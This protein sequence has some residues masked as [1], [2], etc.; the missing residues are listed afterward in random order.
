MAERWPRD[1]WLDAIWEDPAL[2]PNERVVAYVYARYAG[3]GDTAWVSWPE[4]M[5][6]TGMTSKRTVSRALKVLT[7][8]GWLTVV[9]RARQHRSTVYR[10]T[11]PAQRYLSATAEPVDNP[12]SGSNGIP[13][14]GLGQEPAVAIV[15]SSGSD[16]TPS[17]VAIWRPITQIE[18][19]NERSDTR[20]H[21][22]DPSGARAASDRG[23]PFIA[24]VSTGLCTC[25]LPEQ[26][27]THRRTP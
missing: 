9:A 11:V 6:R 17:A 7:D 12:S 20:V 4:I 27:A 25:G 21:A 16:L 10:L 26:N 22:R 15:H 23:H 24:D 13:L 19:S 14:D 5:L 18:N 8:L 1:L 3:S 2:K